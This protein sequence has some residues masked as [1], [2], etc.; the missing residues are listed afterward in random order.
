M[1][2]FKVPNDPRPHWLGDEDIAAGW[3]ALLPDGAAEISDDEARAMLSALI[4][5]VTEADVIRRQIAE[6]ES[7]QTDR[8]IRE[9]ILSGDHSFIES[10]EAQIAELR[11]QLT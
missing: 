3:R 2:N 1:P 7:Q 6:L 11:K 4:P 8:R 5:E 9:A 10:I